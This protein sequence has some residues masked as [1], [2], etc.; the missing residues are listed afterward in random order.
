MVDVRKPAIGELIYFG[1]L[2]LFRGLTV[3]MV[4]AG[5]II[6]GANIAKAFQEYGLPLTLALI[7]FGVVFSLVAC[8]LFWFAGGM[9]K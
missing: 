4:I 1:F 3:C 8:G 7:G 2:Y 6:I 5:W 9:Q